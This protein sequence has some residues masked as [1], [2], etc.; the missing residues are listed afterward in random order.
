MPESKSHNFNE[1]FFN[2][3]SVYFR[4]HDIQNQLG[5]LKRYFEISDLDIDDYYL[6]LL[7]SLAYAYQDHGM[8]DENILTLERYID[9]YRE[10][11]GE[12]D[13]KIYEPMIRLANALYSDARYSKALSVGSKAMEIINSSANLYS[14]DYVKSLLD[15]AGYYSSTGN[16]N[17]SKELY[18]KA[19]L[20]LEETFDV[21]TA[22]GYQ[23]GQMSQ[24][25]EHLGDTQNA[26]NY[27]TLSTE[28]FDPTRDKVSL[29]KSKSRLGVMLSYSGN[30]EEAYKIH[31]DLLEQESSIYTQE[32]KE[33]AY[34]QLAIAKN[35]E[36]AG[37]YQSAET[38]YLQALKTNGKAFNRSVDLDNSLYEELATLYFKI[39]NYGNSYKYLKKCITYSRDQISK[40]FLNLEKHDKEN[41]WNSN[42]YLFLK[43][44][45]NLAVNSLREDAIEAMYDNTFLFAKGLISYT[46]SAL[47]YYAN[48]DPEI[49]TLYNEIVNKNLYRDSQLRLS[50]YNRITEIEQIDKELRTLH[51]KIASICNKKNLTGQFVNVS[52]KDVKKAL[53]DEDIVIDFFAIQDSSYATKGE[54]YFA[55]VLKKSYSSPKLLRLCYENDLEGLTDD[56]RSMYNTVWKAL[57]NELLGMK[58]IYFSP[59]RKLTNIPIEYA[60]NS[61]GEVLFDRY[62][63]YRLSSSRELVVR[64]SEQPIKNVVLYGG[65]KYDATLDIIQAVNESNGYN[66]NSQDTYRGLTD[67]LTLR[68]G[69][70]YLPYSLEEVKGIYDLCT[71]KKTDVSSCRLITGENGTE[72]SF[73]SLYGQ[74]INLIHIATHGAY[75]AGEQ[76]PYYQKLFHED[77][78]N[79][80]S[81]IDNSL[82]RS[83][84]VMSGGDMLCKGVVVPEGM[85]DGILSAKEISKLDFQGL[86]LAVISTCNSGVGDFSSEGT[87][88]IQQGFKK[89]GAKSILMTVDYIDDKATNV[90]MISFY[91]NLLEGNSKYESLQKAL[92]YLRDYDNG[93]YSDPKYWTSFILLDAIE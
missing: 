17:K 16:I 55:C 5:I 70:D 50:E 60:V 78:E 46:E 47:S 45:P 67:S 40:D 82:S 71:T 39:G 53:K 30:Y 87:M 81:Q 64:S 51:D 80:Y 88:G 7:S 77:D 86:E 54:L 59:W 76:S 35:F 25:Y 68:S 32:S 14:D 2:I 90:F 3:Y 69:F 75:I 37:N 21:E 24:I 91:K 41:L 15:M 72:E 42:D 6:F 57:E 13:K 4:K 66:S 29:L 58:R 31:K 49:K 79:R 93:K 74:D 19:R 73:K 23:C 10:Y 62:K 61:E 9:V 20:I 11:R 1:L 8:T 22:N 27:M 33:Y 63:C 85:D 48:L 52:W 34:R 36:R 44:L 83:F 26:I 12:K 89:A 56:F 38:Y 92:R 43:K 84:V 28:R 18:E 65:L